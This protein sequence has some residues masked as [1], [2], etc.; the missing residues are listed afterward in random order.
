MF[1]TPKKERKQLLKYLQISNKE[2]HLLCRGYLNYGKV[3]QMQNYKITS[4]WHEILIRNVKIIQNGC[5]TILNELV[6]GLEIATV[7]F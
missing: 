7:S 2:K 5:E 4:D 3:S 6:D 1:F